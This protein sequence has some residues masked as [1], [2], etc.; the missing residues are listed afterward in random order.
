MATPLQWATRCVYILVMCNICRYQ[1]DLLTFIDTRTL[2][3]KHEESFKYE[4][5]ISY[6]LMMYM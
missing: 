4:V 1:E 3:V 6:D 2:K 5:M